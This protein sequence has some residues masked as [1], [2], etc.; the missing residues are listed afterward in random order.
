MQNIHNLVGYMST[1][2]HFTN[3]WVC[4]P[5]NNTPLSV[6]VRNAFR[7]STWSPSRGLC[8][9]M[10]NST[11]V[12]LLLAVIKQRCITVGA[13]FWIKGELPVFVVRPHA[14][15]RDVRTMTFGTNTCI[16]PPL[17]LMYWQYE[18]KTVLMSESLNHSFNQFIQT[19]DSFRKEARYCFNEQVT[20]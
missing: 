3:S 20:E 14:S 11:F 2:L 1:K 12:V 10:H 19:A 13:P 7:I 15:N 17:V 6:Y 4:K 8:F 18:I 5:L 16:V 9:Q